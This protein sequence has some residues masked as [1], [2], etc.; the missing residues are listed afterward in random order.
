MKMN[1]PQRK[2]MMRDKERSILTFEIRTDFF[3][4]MNR[5]ALKSEMVLFVFGSYFLSF[6]RTKY[7]SANRN[8]A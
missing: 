5:L 7:G 2:G 8:V 1:L 4:N 3:Y 6:F